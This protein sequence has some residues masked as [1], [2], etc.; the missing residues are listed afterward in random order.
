VF[1]SEIPGFESLP[2]PFKGVLRISSANGNVSVLGI[3]G[4]SNERG[5]FLFTTTPATNEKSPTP[6]QIVFPHIVDGGGYTTQFI[7]FSGTPAEPT[8]GSLRMF[9]QSG[10]ALNIGLR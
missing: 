3:R 4:R 10:N 5:D 2:R 7:T 1:L 6:S 9:T 8:S